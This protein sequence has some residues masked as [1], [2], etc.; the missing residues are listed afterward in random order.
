MA[1]HVFEAVSNVYPV[2][3]YVQLSALPEHVAHGDE[4]LTHTPVVLRN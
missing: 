2:M 3:H 1:L 4:Q